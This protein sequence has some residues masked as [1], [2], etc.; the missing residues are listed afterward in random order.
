MDYFS[1]I[2]KLTTTSSSSVITVLKTIFARYEIPEIMISDNG[3]QYV[4]WKMNQFVRQ[5]GFNHLTSSPH[6]PQSNSQAE[7]A[8]QTVKKLLKQAE[9]PWVALLNYRA[10]PLPWCNLSPAELLMGR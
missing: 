7:R 8:V 2:S 1:E 9:E 5:Y 4:S 3:P 6:Y 10:A